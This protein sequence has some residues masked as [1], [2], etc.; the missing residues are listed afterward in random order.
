[1]NLRRHG[2][3]RPAL[4]LGDLP[5]HFGFVLTKLPKR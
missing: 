3:S 5:A 1:M 2:S 4:L